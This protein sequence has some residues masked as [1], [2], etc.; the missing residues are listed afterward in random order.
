MPTNPEKRRYT[1]TLTPAHVKRFQD[2]CKRLGMPTSTMSKAFDDTL[3]GLS[4]TL[5]IAADQGASGIGD[6]VTMM[7]KQ[8]ELLKQ[9]QIK[10]EEEYSVIEKRKKKAST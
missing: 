3:V 10:H 8:M 9:E 1:V 2:I 7:G 5:Q 4:D 6:I